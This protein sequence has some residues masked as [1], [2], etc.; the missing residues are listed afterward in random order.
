MLGESVAVSWALVE[1]QDHR[2]LTIEWVERNGPAI[3]SPTRTGFGSQLLERVL[4]YQVGARTMTS[5]EPDGLWA[6]IAVALQYRISASTL[7]DS[8]ARR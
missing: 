6:L 4:N 5:Y 2:H 8:F 1:D 7:M 3:N